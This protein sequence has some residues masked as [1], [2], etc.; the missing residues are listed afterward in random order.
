MKFIQIILLILLVNGCSSNKV[1]YSGNYCSTCNEW[2]PLWRDGLCLD[3]I[4]YDKKVL[5]SMGQPSIMVAE[6]TTT[7]ERIINEYR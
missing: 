1:S 7:K 2:L 5:T 6:L 4:G 3:C